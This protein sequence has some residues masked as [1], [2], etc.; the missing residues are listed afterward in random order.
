MRQVVGQQLERHLA[1]QLALLG[2]VDDAHAAPAEDPLDA[3]GAEVG[4]QAR[5]GTGSGHGVAPNVAAFASH[6][7]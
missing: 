3:V 7:S 2:E 4:A 6:Q 1:A 5:V